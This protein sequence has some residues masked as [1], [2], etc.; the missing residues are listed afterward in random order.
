MIRAAVLGCGRIGA[1]LGWESPPPYLYNHCSAYLDLKDRVELAWVFDIDPIKASRTGLRFGVPGVSGGE[2][3]R[4][5]LAYAMKWQPVDVVS[6][7]TRPEQREDLIKV[8]R[9]FTTIRGAWI[10]KPLFV[11]AWPADWT[12]NVNYIRRFDV[13]HQALTDGERR[14]YRLWVWAKKNLDTVCHFTDLARFWGLGRAQLRYFPMDGPNSYV[15][16]LEDGSSRFFPLGGIPDGSNF[17]VAALGNLLDA[18]EGRAALLSPP[19][20]AMESEAWADEILKE[21]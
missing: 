16:E 21:P 2:H 12:I 7:C 6:I 8:L 15:A 20:N 5:E 19:E 4:A 3:W 14:V 10:E 13:S 9:Q 17:M 11:R 1:G 18:M